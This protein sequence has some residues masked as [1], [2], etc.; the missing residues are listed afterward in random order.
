MAISEFDEKQRPRLVVAVR[1]TKIMKTVKTAQ[2][3]DSIALFSNCSTSTVSNVCEKYAIAG[4]VSMQQI[5]D[6]SLCAV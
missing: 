2:V 1:M 3:E 5:A 4:Q 6:L